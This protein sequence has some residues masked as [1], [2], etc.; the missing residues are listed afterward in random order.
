L[1]ITVVF[2]GGQVGRSL[3]ANIDYS[4]GH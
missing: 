3:S 4:G 1:S 2:S